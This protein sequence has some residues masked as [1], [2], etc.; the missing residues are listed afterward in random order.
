MTILRGPHPIPF[1]IRSLS[2]SRP[3]VLIPQGI[4]R[5]GSRRA[6]SFPQPSLGSSR[7]RAVRA[8]PSKR[9]P[10]RTQSG[11]RGERLRRRRPHSAVAAEA[12]DGWGKEKARRLPTLPI[13]CGIS[14]IGL[15]GLNDRIRNG[16]GCG[17]LGM[18]TGQCELTTA[19]S[20]QEIIYNEYKVVKPHGRLVRV[21]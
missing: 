3:M 4:G 17:P 13:P 20:R 2:P 1:R 12:R 19:W 18:I 7:N 14:T 16:I 11:T 9:E 5:V 6:F 15:E 21:S 8:E 10:W